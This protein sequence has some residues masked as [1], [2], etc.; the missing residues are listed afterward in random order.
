MVCLYVS[1]YL[2]SETV[3]SGSEENKIVKKSAEVKLPVFVFSVYPGAVSEAR[4]ITASIED[5]A[6]SSVVGFGATHISP[7]GADPHP[8]STRGKAGRNHLNEEVTPPPPP[9]G[10]GKRFSQT[11]YQ[12]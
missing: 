6:F 1:I 12:N 9:T 11:I 2:Y 10:I 3:I 7:Q 4:G 8:S 5:H